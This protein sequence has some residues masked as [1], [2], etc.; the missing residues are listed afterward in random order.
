MGPYDGAGMWLGNPHD[1]MSHQMFMSQLAM[2]T[3][4]QPHSDLQRNE[5]QLIPACLPPLYLNGSGDSTAVVMGLRPVEQQ[6]AAVGAIEPFHE[7]TLQCGKDPQQGARERRRPQRFRADDE[8][9]SPPPVSRQGSRAG[10]KG[11]GGSAEDV[12]IADVN[13]LLALADAANLVL[14]EEG[15]PSD[16]EGQPSAHFQS[17]QNGAAR[18]L[19]GQLSVG[20]RRRRSSG[21]NGVDTTCL[22]E[23]P[24]LMQRSA[25]EGAANAT[26]AGDNAKE[27]SMWMEAHTA[28]AS[29]PPLPPAQQADEVMESGDETLQQPSKRCCV[30]PEG[31][32]SAASAVEPAMTAAAAAAEQSTMM[33]IKTADVGIYPIGHRGS[34]SGAAPDAPVG[35][36]GVGSG[37]TA[38][39]SCYTND[40]GGE[41]LLVQQPTAS[42]AVEESV[43]DTLSKLAT[44]PSLSGAERVHL[45]KSYMMAVQ[46]FVKIS[47]PQP[48]I[49]NPFCM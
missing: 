41:G 33:T 18:T 19:S 29:L 40:G 46:S 1:F 5:Q 7:Q 34:S 10:T 11:G 21:V 23:R 6:Q 4:A 15:A 16:A 28:A 8:G 3:A 30:R 26:A 35:Q 48:M 13:M 2:F 45:I 20:G 31:S 17:R 9:S 38:S 12:G 47:N 49:S 32:S 39:P 42:A 27:V 24:L 22:P 44:D 36:H 43:V 14:S 37:L 25:C